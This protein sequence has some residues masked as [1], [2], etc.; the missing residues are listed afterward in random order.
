MIE[1]GNLLLAKTDA[2]EVY[3]YGERMILENDTYD[4]F[5]VNERNHILLHKINY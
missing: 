1:T 2:E 4:H 5:D 3:L